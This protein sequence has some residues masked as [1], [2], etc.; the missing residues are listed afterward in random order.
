MKC[1]LCNSPTKPEYGNIVCGRH[2]HVY[3][4]R[5]IEEL[6]VKLAAAGEIIEEQSHRIKVRST[7]ISEDESWFDSNLLFYI[8]CL[9][10]FSAGLFI[11]KT[12]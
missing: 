4:E 11:G 7:G 5:C 8:A 6:K 3:Y 9:G 12:L 10:L 2:K 1:E